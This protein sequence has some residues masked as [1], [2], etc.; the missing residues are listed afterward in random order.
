MSGFCQP[1]LGGVVAGC[2]LWMAPNWPKYLLAQEILL[3]SDI[4]IEIFVPSFKK[5]GRMWLK[6]SNNIFPSFLFKYQNWNRL[7]YMPTFR[8]TFIDLIIF[9]ENWEYL[10]DRNAVT[11]WYKR[12]KEDTLPTMG[13]IQLDNG[14]NFCTL[15]CKHLFVYNFRVRIIMRM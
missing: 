15:F 2:T 7:K 12:A 11:T 9:I 5:V 10:Y 6:Y 4:L 8:S 3:T 14:K 13:I 1:P